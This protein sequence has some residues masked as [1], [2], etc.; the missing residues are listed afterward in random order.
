[1]EGASLTNFRW[2]K[3]QFAQYGYKLPQVV[4]WN[5]ASRNRQQP[6]TQHENGVALV[7]GAN[8]RIFSMLSEGELSPYVFMMEVIGGERYEKIAA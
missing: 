5:V 4:F 8:P 3:C 2:A 7:S 6:V 1:V